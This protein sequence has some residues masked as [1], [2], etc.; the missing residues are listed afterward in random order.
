M[1]TNIQVVLAFIVVV[2][3]GVIVYQNHLI[4][5]LQNDRLRDAKETNDKMAAPLTSISQTINL[6]YDKLRNGRQ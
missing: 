3:S 6:I 2:L 1:S 4:T 5:E